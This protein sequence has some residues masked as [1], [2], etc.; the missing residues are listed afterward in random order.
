MVDP[1]VL[2]R[3]HLLGE[4]KELHQL[5][6]HIEAGSIASVEGHAD[7]GQIDTSLILE[8]HETLVEEM[9]E[10]GYNHKSP[11]EYEDD[12]NLGE[13]EAESNTEELIDRCEDCRERY[14]GNRS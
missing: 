9:K 14:E 5:V 4:H 13:I 11:L 10:R 3:N 1:K 12:L 6:G 8:R 2:C 7:R